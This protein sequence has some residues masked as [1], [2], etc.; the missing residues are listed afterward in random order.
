MLYFRNAP[1]EFDLALREALAVSEEL[2]HHANRRGFRLVFLYL[3]S[4]LESEPELHAEVLQPIFDALEVTPEEEAAASACGDAY[5]CGLEAL[6]CETLDLRPLLRNGEQHFWN[7]DLHL[8]LKGQA[9]L[10]ASLLDWY[11]TPAR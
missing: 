1:S 4:A 3:P 6:G 2:Q 8:N 5:L 10:A 7:R 9:L 11:R